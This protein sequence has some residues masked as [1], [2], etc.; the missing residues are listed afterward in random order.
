MNMLMD[1]VKSFFSSLRYANRIS[2]LA[3]WDTKSNISKTAYLAPG[4][5]I[6]NSTIGE[7]SRVR[8]FVTMH[9]TKVGKYSAIGKYV[10]IGLGDHPLNLISTNAIFYSHKKNETR[11]DWVRAIDFSEHNETVIGN[12]VWIG[13]S[14]TIVGGVK[15]GHGAVIATKAV[16]TK[17][18]PPYAVV[19]GIPAKIIKYRFEPEVIQKLIEIKWWDLPESEIEQSLEAFTIFDI[20]KEQLESYFGK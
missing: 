8:Q 18:V 16:V 11:S 12:D 17:D 10:K 15:I 5:V 9:F 3:F 6:G 13:E 4:A 1:F 7:H 14:V 20:N 2:F 19:G